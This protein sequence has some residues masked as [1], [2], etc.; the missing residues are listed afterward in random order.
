[1]ERPC[2]WNNA[3]PRRGSPL[4]RGFRPGRDMTEHPPNPHFREESHVHTKHPYPHRTRVRRPCRRGDSGGCTGRAYRHRE[5]V[6][7]CVGAPPRF[8]R[9]RISHRGRDGR[10]HRAPHP[11]PVGRH[12]RWAPRP[13][14]RQPPGRRPLV[15]RRRILR[16][17]PPLQQRPHTIAH[18]AAEPACATPCLCLTGPMGPGRTLPGPSGSESISVHSAS[19]APCAGHIGAE[20]VCDRGYSSCFTQS[21]CPRLGDF[22][23]AHYQP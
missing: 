6:V 11:V 3:A 1:M 16:H 19:P 20:I 23:G 15:G 10:I 12:W 17:Q 5:N 8:H 14:P 18:V 7:V 22:R 9:D 13:C 2:R 21:R 4:R